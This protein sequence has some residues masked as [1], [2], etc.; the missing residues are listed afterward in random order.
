[1]TKPAGVFLQIIGAFML[2]YALGSWANVDEPAPIFSTVASLVL[3]WVGGI[4]ARRKG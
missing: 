3:L 4:P 1:M 2:L